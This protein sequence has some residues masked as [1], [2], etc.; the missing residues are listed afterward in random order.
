MATIEA[1]KLRRYHAAY[2]IMLGQLAQM[3]DKDCQQ[4][5]NNHGKKSSGPPTAR[6]QALSIMLE[7]FLPPSFQRV[8]NEL[9]YVQSKPVQDMS[10]RAASGMVSAAKLGYLGDNLIWLTI[11]KDY[12]AIAATAREA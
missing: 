9:V 2:P 1:D 3:T 6:Q 7:S 11:Y 8:N 4:L 10:P 5:V 12:P